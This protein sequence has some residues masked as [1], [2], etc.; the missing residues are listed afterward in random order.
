M[1]MAAGVFARGGRPLFLA[2][3]YDDRQQCIAIHF[4]NTFPAARTKRHAVPDDFFGIS[5]QHGQ[6]IRGVTERGLA[7]LQSGMPEMIVS[8]NIGC[9]SHLASGAQVPVKQWIVARDG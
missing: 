5:L 7:A 2:V 4:R 1:D 3:R 9:Q 6:Q 8:S